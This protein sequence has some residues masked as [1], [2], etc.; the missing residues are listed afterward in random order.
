[1]TKKSTN[2]EVLRILLMLMVVVLHACSYTGL[3]SNTQMPMFNQWGVW[4]IRSLAYVAV[5]C[6]VILNGYLMI[7]KEFKL[8]RIIKVWLRVLIY[9]IIIFT[10]L[11]IFTK[12]TYDGG[13]VREIIKNLIPVTSNR[14]WFA[15]S[16]IIL[17]FI[18]PILN[19]S[20]TNISKREYHILLIIFLILFSILPNFYFIEDTYFVNS[21]YSFIWFCYL[22]SVGGYIKLYNFNFSKKYSLLLFVLI[23]VF[24]AFT[25]VTLP[26]TFLYEKDYLKFFLL[27]LY[28]YNSVL[29][30]I[31][32]IAFFNIFNFL[33]TYSTEKINKIIC[34]LGSASFGVYLIHENLYLKS[35]IWNN[36]LIKNIL[37]PNSNY[38]IIKYVLTV[39]VL[40]IIM[41]TISII[42]EFILKKIYEWK[43]KNIYDIIDKKIGFK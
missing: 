40:F 4:I 11:N 24:F 41:I 29:I 13:L 7:N 20:L 39:I 6:F 43:L 34:L 15:T 26:N 18:T 35:Y 28:S 37:N 17:Q 33:K 19:R 8:S 21:G 22:Y 31:Q 30:L 12:C 1:M 42:I 2:F 5:N 16:F 3:L 23:G 38:L 10:I 32:S 9:S 25:R 36:E 14:Y 27:Y